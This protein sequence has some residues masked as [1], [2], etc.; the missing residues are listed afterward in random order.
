M[1]RKIAVATVVLI[2]LAAGFLLVTIPDL[3]DLL[4]RVTVAGSV[5]LLVVA[6]AFV[7]FWLLYFIRKREFSQE[8]SSKKHL[9]FFL[10]FPP[11][12]FKDFGDK[13]LHYFLIVRKGK[14]GLC[15]APHNHIVDM[16]REGEKMMYAN[17]EQDGK[18]QKVVLTSSAIEA[19]KGVTLKDL[20]EGIKLEELETS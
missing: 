1:E 10:D 13:G 14:L 9:R 20:E 3:P 16:R 6:G 8:L 19:E 18:W 2:A 12:S 17:V 7:W 15:H 5:V 11:G 4:D